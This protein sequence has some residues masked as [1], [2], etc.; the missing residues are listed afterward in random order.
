MIIRHI[1]AAA[2]AILIFAATAR[3]LCLRVVDRQTFN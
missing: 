2:V 1:A 3:G